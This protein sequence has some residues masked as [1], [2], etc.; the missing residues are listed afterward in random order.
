[1]KTGTTEVDTKQVHTYLLTPRCMYLSPGYGDSSGSPTE[2]GV[3]HDGYTVYQW[4]RRQ[5]GDVPIYI[6]GHSM[7]T[8]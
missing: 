4:L 1:M 7:G 2:D 6:W 3:C 5:A 8:G